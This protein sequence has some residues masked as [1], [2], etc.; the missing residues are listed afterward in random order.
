MPLK[1]TP[2]VVKHANLPAP[3]KKITVSTDRTKKVDD[4]RKAVTFGAV[5]DHYNLSFEDAAVILSKGQNPYD[6]G[7]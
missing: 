7:M 6:E 4:A 3:A 1:K 2:N 5:C